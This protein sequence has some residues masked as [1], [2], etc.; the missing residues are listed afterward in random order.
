MPAALLASLAAPA[1]ADTHSPI[2]SL[3]PRFYVVMDAGDKNYDA[4]V[5]ISIAQ[6][7]SR[8]L[9]EFHRPPDL[10]PDTQEWDTEAAPWVVPQP[11]WNADS[12]ADRCAIDD[13]ALGGVVISY[14]TGYA[15]HFYLLWQS[16][17]TTM[18]L[19]AELVRCNHDAPPGSRTPPATVVGVITQLPGADN[20]DWIV[21][22][23]QIS[24]P[25]ITFAAIGSLI[26]PKGNSAKTSSLTLTALAGSILGSSGTRDIPGYSEPVR[27]RAA[28]KHV[29][30]DV[31]TATTALCKSYDDV[32]WNEY[33]RRKELCDR[34]GFATISNRPSG[35]ASSPVPQPSASP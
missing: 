27:I 6:E 30:D 3:K 24:I 28:A 22:R 13:Q 10:E 32:S 7:L 12:L 8:K 25:L 29:G 20:T 4:I 33:L 19:F 18:E 9:A 21:R 31:V 15:S 2:G 17:T 1:S 16:Q 11:A 5:T 14:Y 26:Q 34:L 35:P 23:S